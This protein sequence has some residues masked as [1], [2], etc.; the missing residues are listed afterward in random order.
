MNNELMYFFLESS[1]LRPSASLFFEKIQKKKSSNKILK[2]NVNQHSTR[3][4]IRH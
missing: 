1:L 4:Y 3:N 2:I